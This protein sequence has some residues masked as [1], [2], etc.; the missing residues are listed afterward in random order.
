MEE[1]RLAEELLREGYA[2][3]YVWED[4]P[5]VDYPEHQHRAESTH[6]ILK[7][8]MTLTMNGESK[9]YRNGDRCDLPAGIRH[10]ARIGPQGCRY[11]IGER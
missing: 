4:G 2:H 1:N 11:L 7:G 3:L 10:S 5:N 9:T 8:E 6:I